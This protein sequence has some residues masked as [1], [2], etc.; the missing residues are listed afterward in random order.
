MSG[1]WNGG[2]GAYRKALREE[3]RATRKQLQSRL[4]ECADL[5]QRQAVLDELEKLKSD[6]ARRLRTLRRSMFGTR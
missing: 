1:I 4:G 6:Y 5:L 3:Y 2:E